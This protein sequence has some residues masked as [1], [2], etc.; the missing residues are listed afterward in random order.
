MKASDILE[1]TMGW[2]WPVIVALGALVAWGIA[3][4][5]SWESSGPDKTTEP[6]PAE[7]VPYLD[8]QRN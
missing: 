1:W 3:R 2:A 6:V 7:C 5:V 8:R 4:F